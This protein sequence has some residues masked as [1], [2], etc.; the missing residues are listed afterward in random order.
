MVSTLAASLPM[1]ARNVRARTGGPGDWW[2]AAKDAYAAFLEVLH[3]ACDPDGQERWIA[4]QIERME[5][6]A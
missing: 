6:W 5:G 1:A 4:R 2:K 3:A